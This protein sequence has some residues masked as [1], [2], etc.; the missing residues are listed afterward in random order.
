MAEFQIFHSESFLIPWLVNFQPMGSDMFCVCGERVEASKEE[1][2]DVVG[3]WAGG[4]EVGIEG[5]GGI[6]GIQPCK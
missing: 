3:T 4:S 5:G 1:E 2:R 6:S